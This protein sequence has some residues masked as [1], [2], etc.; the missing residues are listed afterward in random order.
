MEIDNKGFDCLLRRTDRRSD[1]F[2]KKGIVLWVV[3]QMPIRYT[4]FGGDSGGSPDTRKKDLFHPDYYRGTFMDGQPACR[5]IPADRKDDFHWKEPIR[6]EGNLSGS[7][8]TG[9]EN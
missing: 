9:A 5:S 7:M 3:F 2:R 1:G 6:R 8:Q 4:H